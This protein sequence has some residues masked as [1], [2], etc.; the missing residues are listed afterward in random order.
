M[1]EIARYSPDRGIFQKDI[2]QSQQ[3]SN[4]YL[5]HIIHALKVAGLIRK[6]GHKGGF[7]LTRKP[8]EITLFDINNAFEPG[9]CV[10]D[11]LECT[12][13]CPHELECSTKEFWLHLNQTIIGVFKSHS[14]QSLLDEEEIRNGLPDG[15][16]VI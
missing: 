12:V 13:K 15:E 16:P 10:I 3:I 1:V 6:L 14:L 8:S 4:K 2:A 11:C 9:I 7:I 5:D